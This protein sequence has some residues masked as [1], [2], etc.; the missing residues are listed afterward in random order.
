MSARKITAA[1][2]D[3]NA[4]PPT[5]PIRVAVVEDDPAFREHLRA[6]ITGAPGF[7][8]VGAY[9]DAETALACLSQEPPDVLVLDL[10]L[11]GLSGLECLRLLKPQW[12]R[13]EILVLT[14]HDDAQRLFEALEAGASGYLHK[15]PTSAAHVLEAIAEVHRGGSPMSASIARS[16]V[17]TFQTRPRRQPEVIEL[18]ER[19][20]EILDQL[21][22]GFQAKEIADALHIT[23]STVRAHLHHIYDKLHVRSGLEAALKYG[24]R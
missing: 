22:H 6:L 4:L 8:C 13:L 17:K 2:A 24:P 3:A 10:G 16:V 14:I 20:K 7:S 21:T 18:S 5:E 11:P 15:P 19:E 12:P 23:V 1:S 9:P